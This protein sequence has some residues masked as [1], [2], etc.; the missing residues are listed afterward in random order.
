MLQIDVESL[1]IKI[2]EEPGYAFKFKASE[3]A[4][5]STIKNWSSKGVTIDFSPKFDWV[6]GGLKTEIDENKNARQY[7]CVKAGSTM[8]I[9]YNVFGT[10]A[11]GTG[12]CFK[13]IFKAAK[14]KDYDAQVL[15]C[16][17]GQRGM[18]LRAQNAT[19]NSTGVEFN[20]PY[21]E[22]S[23]IELEMDITPNKGDMRRYIRPWIDGVPA[24]I[25]VYEPTDDF[26]TH[27][28]NRLVIGSEDCDVY[29]YLIKLYES[30]LSDTSH[31][32]NFIADAPNA[33][34]M[35]A[36]F[37]RNDILDEND[38]IS[39]TR[40]AEA[41]PNCRVHMYEMS[42]MTMHKKDPIENCNYT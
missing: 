12:K 2:E 36:R 9:N 20:I 5:N 17:D 21:C 29:I 32:N 14:C 8:T 13:V 3:F 31:L 41:N 23:Y 33:P 19:F 22:E 34:E 39:P 27:P 1:G 16:H 28:D 11:R 24:G 38:E 4:D 40:L 42:R 30:H 37:R 7:V 26:A 15:S 10:D 6:N 25:K 35:I 18:I